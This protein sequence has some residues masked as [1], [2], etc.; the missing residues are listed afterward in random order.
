MEKLSMYCP[1][2]GRYLESCANSADLKTS[3]VALLEACRNYA[4]L[5]AISTELFGARITVKERKYY[6]HK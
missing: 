2:T 4:E 1:I 3:G 6:E 5:Q